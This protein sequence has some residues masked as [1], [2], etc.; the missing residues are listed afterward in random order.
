MAEAGLSASPPRKVAKMSDNEHTSPTPIN[1]AF[2]SATVSDAIPP[3]PVVKK[4]L[5]LSTGLEKAGSK[6]LVLKPK[7]TVMDR[8][9]YDSQLLSVHRPTAR[10]STPADPAAFLSQTLT[11]LT[12]A[13]RAILT[14]T[15][16]PES[17]QALYTLC[18]QAVSSGPSTSQTLYDRV[19]LEIERQTGEVRRKLMSC[20]DGDAV[21]D[22]QLE[23]WLR[24]F[25]EQSRQFLDQ[26][27]LV[28]SVLLHLD[29]TYVLQSP[30][31]LS[32]W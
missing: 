13:A 2:K 8:N 10:T 23:T 14:S 30:T 1:T 20:S 28:R 16:T 31:L 22:S 5:G 7:G 9:R 27:L 18:E 21:A 15:P 19:R 25:D 12:R 29:R 32:I 6:K 3:P 4:R 17:L 11:T 24:L 26:V